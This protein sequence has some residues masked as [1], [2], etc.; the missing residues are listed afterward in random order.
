M[1]VKV[2]DGSLR[3]FV[4]ATP[5]GRGCAMAR[6]VRGGWAKSGT[7]RGLV[8]LLA[9]NLRPALTYKSRHTCAST[10]HRLAHPA[11]YNNFSQLI[12]NKTITRVV[13][14]RNAQCLIRVMTIGNRKRTQ[15]S[16]IS[17]IQHVISFFAPSKLRLQFISFLFLILLLFHSFY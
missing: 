14:P 11:P 9:R 4:N 12:V 1:L 7:Q 16:G 8:L 6:K 13:N 2:S 17:V 5:T 10:P 3:C 15:M